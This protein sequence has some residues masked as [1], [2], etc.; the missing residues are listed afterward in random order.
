[1]ENE[2][3]D[4]TI[5]KFDKK[6]SELTILVNEAKDLKINGIEDKDGYLA[7][8][9]KRMQLVRERTNLSKERLS[10]TRIFD[11]MKKQV[12]DKEKDLLKIIE[13][14]EKE[15]EE[16]QNA[17]DIEKEKIKRLEIL[18]E[19]KAKL[20]DINVSVLDEFLLLMDDKTFDKFLTEKQ[21][22]YLQEKQRQLE[23]KQRQLEEQQRKIDEQNAKIAIEKEL[24]DARKQAE[25]EAQEKAIRDSELAKIKAE[26][27]KKRAVEAEKEKAKREKEAMIAEQKRKDDERIAEEKRLKDEAET[28][29]KA[30]KEAQ[31]KLEKQ[32]KYQK[33]LLDNNYSEETD[34][35]DIKESKVILYR[36]VSEFI[37]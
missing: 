13:P 10:I 16:K 19:R 29:A 4:Q 1:M 18:P 26:E 27:D 14:A 35:L 34:F 32:K 25:K 28:K 37:K 8:H 33:F 30:E 36:K 17:I 31:E 9:S 24:E 5:Q 15:L 21:G 20:E 6:I 23:E 2:K 7:V 3:I 12:M 11:D 22:E